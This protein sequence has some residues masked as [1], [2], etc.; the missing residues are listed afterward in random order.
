MPSTFLITFPLVNLAIKLFSQNKL[1]VTDLRTAKLK[2][3]AVCLAHYQ[4]LSMG[5]GH[6]YEDNRD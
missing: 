6:T 2:P 3:V 1:I 5:H 4:P